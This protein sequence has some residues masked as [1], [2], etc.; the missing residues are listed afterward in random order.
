MERDGL[1]QNLVCGNSAS[2]HE[3]YIVGG[4]IM[5]Q[6]RYSIKRPSPKPRTIILDLQCSTYE[7]FFT[8]ALLPCRLVC[9]LL[10][11][12]GLDVHLLFISLSDHFSCNG[13]RTVNTLKVHYMRFVWCDPRDDESI[14]LKISKCTCELVNKFYSYLKATYLTFYMEI[15]CLLFVTIQKRNTRTKVF[16]QIFHTGE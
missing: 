4:D 9:S 14:P 8:N 7:L 12:Q 15:I 11:T 13:S 5:F 3:I 1:V 2:G 6:I 10:F 16:D